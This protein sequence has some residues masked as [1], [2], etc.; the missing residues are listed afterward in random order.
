MPRPS[1][2]ENEQPSTQVNSAAVPYDGMPVFCS[3]GRGL[4]QRAIAAEFT[5]SSGG[6]FV[7]SGGVYGNGGPEGIRLR[8]SDRSAERGCGCSPARMRG[9]NKR[10]FAYSCGIH[11]NLRSKSRLASF[12]CFS[13]GCGSAGRELFLKAPGGAMPLPR[14]LRSD[15]SG[16]PGGSILTTSRNPPRPRACSGCAGSVTR[17]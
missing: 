2:V 10:K 8:G 12:G 4:R 3:K 6:V 11:L 5:P 1:S 16:I 7:V 9:L 17:K 15:Y 14:E 13:C